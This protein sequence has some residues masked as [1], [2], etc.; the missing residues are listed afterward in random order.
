MSQV[1]NLYTTRIYEEEV[2]GLLVH[3]IYHIQCFGLRHN[4]ALFRGYQVPSSPK[5]L[6]LEAIASIRID[7][8]TIIK[9]VI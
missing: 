9:P 6:F 2:K 4:L 5:T 3:N 8:I 1:P 7:T